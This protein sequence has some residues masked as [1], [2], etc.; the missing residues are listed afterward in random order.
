[1]SFFVGATTPATSRK[2]LT[3]QKETSPESIPP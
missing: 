1:L 3:L 2:L